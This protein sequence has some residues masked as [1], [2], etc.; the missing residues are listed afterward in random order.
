MPASPAARPHAS[1]TGDAPWPKV[2]IV[3]PSFNQG[4]YIEETIRSVL[5]QDYPNLEYVIIDGGSTDETVSVIRKYESSLTYW[6]SEPDRGQTHAINKGFEHT[7]GDIL[8]YLNSDDILLPGALREVVKQFRQQDRPTLVCCAGQYFGSGVDQVMGARATEDG[9]PRLW[10][11]PLTPRLT[12]W[13]TTYTSLLQQSTFWNRKLHTAL[14]GF[15]EAFNFCF[16]KDFFLRAIFEQQA[17]IACPSILAAGHRMHS[18]M[19]TATIP[20]V[21]IRENE[22]I[23]RHYTPLPWAQRLLER[24]RRAQR[25]QE[26]MASCLNHPRLAARLRCLATSAL[27]WPRVMSQRMFWGAVRRTLSLR[28]GSP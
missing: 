14:G 18:E 20:D 9:S 7:T 21:M 3:T 10:S 28:A 24:E 13:L 1:S 25:A 16:D 2:S 19:K 5:M 26:L 27:L 12:D 6:V 23:W 8:C 17:Y 15:P 22:T 11:P 4:P